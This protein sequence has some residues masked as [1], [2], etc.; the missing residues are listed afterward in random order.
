MLGFFKIE[1]NCIERAYI[2]QML[3]NYLFHFVL[4]KV[5]LY[6]QAVNE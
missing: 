2:W 1:N 6:I 5:F 3:F 4:T